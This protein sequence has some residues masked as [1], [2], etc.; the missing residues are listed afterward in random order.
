MEVMAPLPAREGK[1]L[2]TMARGRVEEVINISQ[3]DCY[4]FIPLSFLFQFPLLQFAK[5]SHT[6]HQPPSSPSQTLGHHG[7]GAALSICPANSRKVTLSALPDLVPVSP[8]S[9]P[10]SG[11]AAEEALLKFSAQTGTTANSSEV[12]S[13]RLAPRGHVNSSR[14][15]QGAAKH[16]FRSCSIS[17][18]KWHHPLC[19]N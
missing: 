14:G 10:A 18:S 7:G 12:S 9:H 13:T 4:D 6:S 3:R 11:H 15:K 8:P 2:P 19:H 5:Q 17:H 16:R 1:S